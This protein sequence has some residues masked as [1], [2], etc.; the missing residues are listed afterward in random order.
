[1]KKK[2][3]E[4]VHEGTSMPIEEPKGSK[5]PDILNE[6]LENIGEDNHWILDHIFTQMEQEMDTQFWEYVENEHNALGELRTR[7]QAVAENVTK[8]FQS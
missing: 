1:M 4:K 2:G 3:K 6:Y 7:I 8:K 5:S